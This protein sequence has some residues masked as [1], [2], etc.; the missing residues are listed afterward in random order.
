MGFSRMY[1]PNGLTNT[2]LSQ[3]CVLENS[4]HYGNGG[5]NIHSKDRG[6]D[7]KPLIAWISSWVNQQS[8]SLNDLLQRTVR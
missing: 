7:E 4:S 3:V 5:Q 6:E 8:C 2:L 1:Y